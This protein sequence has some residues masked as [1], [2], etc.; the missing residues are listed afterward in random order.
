MGK[1]PLVNGRETI[2]QWSVAGSYQTRAALADPPLVVADPQPERRPLGFTS[3][4]IDFRPFGQIQIGGS[5]M[6]RTSIIGAVV[7]GAVAAAATAAIAQQPGQRAAPSAPAAASSTKPSFKDILGAGYEIK[8][9][10]YVPKEG[11]STTA[12]DPAVLVTLQKGSALA[13][14][15]FY[16]GNWSSAL[17]SSLEGTSQCDLYPSFVK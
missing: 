15:E 8:A 5:D 9:V 2:D 14:C 12:T 13:V 7:L 1:S 3:P 16:P 11:I 17:P 10:T 6:T 4:M